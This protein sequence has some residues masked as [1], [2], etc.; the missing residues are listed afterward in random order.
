MRPNSH[1]QAARS[2]GRRALHRR[3][4]ALRRLGR[5]IRFGVVGLSGVV[6]YSVVLWLLVKSLG[7]AV[8]AGSGVASEA[9]IIS[10]F[11]LND[12]WTFR[13][14]ATNR[15][16]WQR[17]LR[18]NGVALGGLLMT[19]LLLTILTAYLHL[20]LLPANLAAVGAA[21]GWN[22]IVNSRWT[23]RGSGES[24][25]VRARAER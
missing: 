24:Y 4:P 12:R 7:L 3:F 1:L 15:R 9:A 11:L 2:D 5:P 14:R 13:T 6:V 23:W 10:N 20:A 19:A 25:P 8:P 17:F 16:W 22:Y 21:T 18:F